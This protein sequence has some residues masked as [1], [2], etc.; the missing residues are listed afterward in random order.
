MRDASHF[1]DSISMPRSFATHHVRAE[2]TSDE[3]AA[4]NRVVV[5]GNGGSGKTTAARRLAAIIDAPV[6]H[7]DA[8]Y[9]DSNWRTLSSEDFAGAQRAIVATK[10]WVIDGNFA[11]TLPIRL[12]A[13][14]MVI[15]LDLH[16]LACLWGICQRRWKYG[17]GQ[18]TAVGIY[19][20]VTWQ[21]IVYVVNYRRKM[22]PRIRR[23]IADHARQARVHIAKSRRALD[24][25]LDT[26]EG[27]A[28]QS[29]RQ[30]RR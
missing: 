22:S 10:R 20:R 13:A 25:L 7:L 24:R 14:D 26:I 11:S 15:F 8:V 2:T 28:R 4:P 5:I 18:H 19:D 12:A 6:T 30:S 17:G 23:L 3:S 29:R 27:N 9:Y 21:F 1:C 16:P